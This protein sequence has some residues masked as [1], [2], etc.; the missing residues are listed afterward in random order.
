VAFESLVRW[1]H[2][3]RGTVSPGEFI[4]TA[5]ETG[6]VVPMGWWMVEA[7]CRQLARWRGE[8]PD[9][10]VAI[11]V[12]LSVR[13]LRQARLL[14]RMLEVLAEHG[15]PPRS[16]K[17]E[18]TESMLMDDVEAQIAILRRLR[19]SGIAVVIDD[20]G[21]GYSSLSYIQRFEF[22]VLKIDRSFLPTG[23]GE[24]GWELVRMIIELAKDKGAATVAEGI[25]TEA[26][27]ARLRTLG[28][29]WGQGFWFA[30][31]LPPEEATARLRAELG[32]GG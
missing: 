11:S 25:E 13:Q 4:P 5:E 28:C 14:D 1:Q 16:L 10:D 30:K 15:V 27:A 7:S 31:P 22:D 9:T 20:F 8:F 26:H 29:D 3:I 23:D 24:D 17:L 21:T 6:L 2:R 19:E 18:V 32:G 12:N